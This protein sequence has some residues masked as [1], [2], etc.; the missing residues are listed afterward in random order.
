MW[1][2]SFHE[3]FNEVHRFLDNYNILAAGTSV[4]RTIII[5]KHEHFRFHVRLWGVMSGAVPRVADP[6]SA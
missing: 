5:V 4:T 6:M 2:A 1:K 3:G